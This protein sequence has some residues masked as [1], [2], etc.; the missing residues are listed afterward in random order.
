VKRLLLILPILA[1]GVWALR[2]LGSPTV[3]SSS[4]SRPAPRDEPVQVA[5]D[6]AAF[7]APLWV[8]PPAPPPAP[9]PAPPPPPLKLQLI[10]IL[11][12][13]SEYR[14]ALYDPEADTLTV[15]GRGDTI[16]GRTIE[17]I[18]AADLDLSDRGLKRTLSLRTDGGAL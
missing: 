5:L 15:V 18:G 7:R 14:A 1:C 2:P 13:G 17:R 16:A 9:A 4:V 12:E 3:V 11:K 10:A 8:A 6:T